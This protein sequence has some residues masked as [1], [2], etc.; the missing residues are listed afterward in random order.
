[1]HRMGRGTARRAVEGH[2]GCGDAI[3]CSIDVRQNFSCGDTQYRE[4]PFGQ[5]R[6]T[7]HVPHW[8]CASIVSL[9]VNLH[10]E[11][12]AGTIKVRDKPADGMLATELGSAGATAKALPKQYFGQAHSLAQATGRADGIDYPS[13]MPRM[14]PLPMLRIGRIRAGPHPSNL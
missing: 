4:S 13:T 14:V 3:G 1:M 9:A 10:D 8:T 12:G 2:S 6:V 5:Y 11:P 7:R